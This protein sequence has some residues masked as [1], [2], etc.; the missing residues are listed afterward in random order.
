MSAPQHESAFLSRLRRALVDDVQ[1]ELQLAMRVGMLQAAGRSRGQVAEKL[2][3]SRSDLQAAYS[4]L[5]RAA[6][7]TGG[8]LRGEQEVARAL[9]R[10]VARVETARSATQ[11]APRAER[12][13]KAS[14]IPRNMA[15]EAISAVAPGLRSG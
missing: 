11:R 6:S 4:R 8:L 12:A 1:A 7:E 9:R 13:R 14:E 3:A 5:D 2:G 10:G 15:D